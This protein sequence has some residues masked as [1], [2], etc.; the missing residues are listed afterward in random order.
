MDYKIN[1]LGEFKNDELENIFWEGE[2]KKGLRLIRYM[3]LFSSLGF[4]LVGAMDLIFKTDIS[5]KMALIIA[6][7]GIFVL[8][9]ALFNGIKKFR[10]NNSIS[11]AICVFASIIYAVYFYMAFQV[12]PLHILSPTFFVILLA[13]CLLIIPNRWIVNIFFSLVFS[14]LFAILVPYI[15]DTT[16]LEHRIIAIM[17]LFWNIILINVLFYNINVYKRNNFA[18]ARQLEALANTDQLTQIHNRKSCDNIIENKCAGNTMFSIIMFD[19]DNFKRINDT[20]GHVAGDAVLIDITDFT[21]SII[22]K[23]DILARWGGEEFLIIML[24]AALS[25]A[26]ELAKRIQEQLTVI[27]HDHIN[28]IIT[29]SFGVTT[30][31]EG[32]TVKS[33]IKRAD[34]LLYLAKEYGKNRVVAG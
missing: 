21:R 23:N 31:V 17:Y 12:R 22:R 16:A 20:Y 14:V 13:T 26:T 19:I 18:K 11:I 6:R 10:S 3:I 24:D 15:C 5:I 1:T 27:N 8:G 32:D 25:E 29:C 34:Q 4:L 28:Q 2:V 7:T 33:I 9:V 30:Y